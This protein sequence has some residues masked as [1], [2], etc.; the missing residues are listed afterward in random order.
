[1]SLTVIPYLYLAHPLPTSR[2][3]LPGAT[4]PSLLV[5][6]AWDLVPP[7]SVLPLTTVL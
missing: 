2:R 6:I 5:A 1:M 3:F 4:L 7:L